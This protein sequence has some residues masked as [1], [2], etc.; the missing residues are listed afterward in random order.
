MLRRIVFGLT[1]ASALLAVALFS[2]AA[3]PAP[4]QP[5]FI[6]LYSRFYDHSHPRAIG[7]RLQRLL[8]LLDRLHNKY[9]ESGISALLQFSGTTA[10]VVSE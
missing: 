2:R 8:P 9:P 7:E 1:G 4:V 6:V 3:E 5:V 10:Q